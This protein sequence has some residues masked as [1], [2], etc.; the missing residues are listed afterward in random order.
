Q[1]HAAAA[2]GVEGAGGALPHLDRIQRAFGRHDVTGISAHVGAAAGDACNDIGA[3]AY[4]TGNSVAFA[5][6]PDLHIAAHEAAHVVQQRAGAQLKGG[7]AEASAASERHADTVADLVVRG[8]SAEAALDAAP[9]GG[10][11]AAVQRFGSLEHQ[12]LGDRA[13]GGATYD[14]GGH[15]ASE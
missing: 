11:H 12:S 10:E 4:A 5:R 3:Q 7:V 15:A 13:T 9:T 6:A 8:E 2:R 1:V 14:M